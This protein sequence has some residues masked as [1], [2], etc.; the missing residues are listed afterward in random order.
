MVVINRMESFV[1]NIMAQSVKVNYILNLINTGSQMLFPLITFPYVCRVIG[2]DGIGQVN[3]YNSIIS[4]ISL[5]TCLGIPM[6]AI[7]EI[8]RDR[9]DV[10]KMNRTATEI[11]LLH[12]LLTFVGYIVVAI[13]CFTVPQ[14]QANIFLFLVLSLTIFFTAIGCEWFYQG[15]EDFKYIT[16]RG[17]IIKTISVILLFIFVRSKSDLLYYGC[18]MVFGI[19]GGNIFNFFRLRKYIHKDNIIFSELRITRHIKPVL[20]VFSMTVVSSIYLQLNTVLLGFI[21]NNTAVGYFSSASKM[22]LMLLAL[23]TSLNG[24]VMPRASNLL[25]ENKQEEFKRL[26]QKSYD[27]SF[28][29]SL[30]ISVGLIICAPNIINVLCGPNFTNSI[31]TS[32]IL[33][34][35][36]FLVA[37]SS[38]IGLQILF[39]KGQVNLI[40]YSCIIGACVDIILNIILIPVY[41]F[42]G[43]ATAYLLAELFSLLSLYMM[44]KKYIPIHFIKRN[45]LVY[46]LSSAIMGITLSFMNRLDLSNF[47][48]LC[49]QLLAGIATYSIVLIIFKDSIFV[50]IL[51]KIKK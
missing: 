50:E 28:A 33:G 21:E 26:L 3:F 15:I 44:G 46:M 11:L 20:K 42:N 41:S 23:S 7:R 32:Q 10:V 9:N 12:T 16:I 36:I 22:M 29:I 40:V 25:V 34:P 19:L 5:F 38:F 31:L 6:Y 30:P 37:V 48:L 14:I 4:Y 18:Y 13:L 49:C 45:Q 2:A 35:I 17:L 39:P 47:K 51:N 24:V 27:F 43:T 8:A 1:F